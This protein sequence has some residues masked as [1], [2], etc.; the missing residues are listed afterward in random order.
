MAVVEIK[1]YIQHIKSR[2]VRTEDYYYMDCPHGIMTLNRP[3]L[4]ALPEGHKWKIY[5]Y[6]GEEIAK[7]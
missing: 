6:K 7:R 3:G 1:K 4:D 2:G 5:N